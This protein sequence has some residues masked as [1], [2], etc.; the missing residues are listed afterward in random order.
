MNKRRV[1][2]NT[3]TAEA[4]AH[5][6]LLMTCVHGASFLVVA[7]SVNTRPVSRRSNSLISRG[8]EV[9]AASFC[10]VCVEV[11]EVVLPN[12][13]CCYSVDCEALITMS[14]S[15]PSAAVQFLWLH[16]DAAQEVHAGGDDW[17][18]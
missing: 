8:V 11:R 12:K 13:L 3:N 9:R 18:E 1:R 14:S 5:K 15:L 10:A 7:A 6:L 16:G 17:R 4:S 2:T